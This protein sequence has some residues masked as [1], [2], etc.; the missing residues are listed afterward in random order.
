M[1]QPSPFPDRGARA[2]ARERKRHAV[3]LA[4]VQMFNERG[5]H[6]TSLDD[7]AAR[8]GI[9]KPVIYHYFG[10]KDQVLLAC[11]RMGVDQ[12]AD[13]ASAAR[14]QEG[15]GLLRL[16][17]FLRCYA[18]VIMDDF[19]RCVVRTGD[20]LLSPESRAEFRA[21]KRE[22]DQS[23][24]ALI[25]EAVAD[26]SA[27]VADVRIAAA[28]L[29]GALNWPAR[30]QRPDGKLSAQEVAARMADFLILSLRP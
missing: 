13:A 24:C 29:A 6:A 19:G 15:S 30:W 12:L 28:A 3:L 22:V 5:F 23:L 11:V 10:N 14:M 17:A 26:G 27:A 2:E 7:V 1:H 8:L 18:L 4:A 21:I 9:T 16:R 20:E 25:E